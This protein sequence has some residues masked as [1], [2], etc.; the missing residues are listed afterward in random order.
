[1]HAACKWH[2]RRAP[3][4]AGFPAGPPGFPAAAG[5]LRD[6]PP[7]PN[8]C[9]SADGTLC[10]AVPAAQPVSAAR[11]PQGERLIAGFSRSAKVRPGAPW[12]T[13]AARRARRRGCAGPRAKHPRSCRAAP[14]P[15]APCGAA[16]ARG[17]TRSSAEQC[18]AMLPRS[19]PAS[20]RPAAPA[21]P[22]PWFPAA[23]GMGIGRFCF[24]S[25]GK[26]KKKAKLGI[27]PTVTAGLKGHRAA[28][29]RHSR[30]SGGAGNAETAEPVRN[31]RGWGCGEPRQSRSPVQPGRRWRGASRAALDADPAERRGAQCVLLTMEHGPRGGWQGAA[32]AAPRSWWRRPLAHGVRSPRSAAQGGERSWGGRAGFSSTP[33]PAC[34]GGARRCQR[35]LR[36]G[37]AWLFP[38]GFRRRQVVS[39]SAPPTAA[40]LPAAAP[41]SAASAR[42]SERRR[43]AGRQ[44][45]RYPP[46]AAGEVR[47]ASRAER[48]RPAAGSGWDRGRGALAGGRERRAPSGSPRAVRSGCGGAV[49][50]RRGLHRAPAT[51]PVPCARP[52]REGWTLAAR[53]ERAA[54]PRGRNP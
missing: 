40:V 3:A 23:G 14:A 10:P 42:R 12:V 17:A 50:C 1:M 5:C 48:R 38:W 18:R 20:H 51:R 6:L 28:P 31:Q 21:T 52:G 9:I 46:S 25:K 16:G 24:H 47:R 4:W 13:P 29:R 33:P 22:G 37:R 26:R 8:H 54:H 19:S 32:P 34:P 53:V 41:G 36:D 27:S 15:D 39:L 11:N 44:G 30:R 2:S 7:P 49:L 35:R 43:P 45:R